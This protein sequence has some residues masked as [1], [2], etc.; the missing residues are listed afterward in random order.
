MMLFQR[1]SK[2]Q[3]FIGC[4]TAIDPLF[5]SFQISSSALPPTPDLAASNN[6]ALAHKAYFLNLFIKHC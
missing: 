3:I 5:L 1:L 2:F 6:Q 4:M